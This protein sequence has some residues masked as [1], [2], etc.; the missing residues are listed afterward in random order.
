MPPHNRRALRPLQLLRPSQVT[1][2]F[3]FFPRYSRSNCKGTQAT[4]PFRAAASASAEPAPR[5]PLRLDLSQLASP[6]DEGQAL[7]AAG[8]AH[9]SI[10]RSLGRRTATASVGFLC[11]LQPSTQTAGMAAARGVDHD[12][13]F[14]GAQLRLGFR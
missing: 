9:T 14:L 4:R 2:F 7:K 12:G 5:T 8:I 11:G 3:P 1:R 6:Y 13:R 10:D